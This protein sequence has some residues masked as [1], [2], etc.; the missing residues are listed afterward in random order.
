MEDGLSYRETR[1][2]YSLV[3]FNRNWA[4]CEKGFGDFNTEFWYE[5]ELVHCL[6]QRGQWEMR[7]DYQKNDKTWSYFS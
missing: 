3:N 1:M 6:G 2:V 4:D 5:L 7:V